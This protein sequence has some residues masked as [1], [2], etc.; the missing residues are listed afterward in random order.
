M[1]ATRSEL[2]DELELAIQVGSA[3]KR[4]QTLGRVTDLFLG[5][6]DRFNDEQI[7]VFDDV[8]GHRRCE[9]ARISGEHWRALSSACAQ[10]GNLFTIQAS[11]RRK[12]AL[13]S[14]GFHAGGALRHNQCEKNIGERH[15][16]Q[17]ER[18]VDR[19]HRIANRGR[20]Y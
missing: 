20:A 2:L 17:I 8:L 15:H 10:Q 4:L 19:H 1:P 3:E 16:D 9:L 6:A 18:A 12:R 11:I 5:G 13:I 7:G 14:G